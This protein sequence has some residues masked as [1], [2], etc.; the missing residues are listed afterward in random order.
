MA[1]ISANLGFLWT[2]RPL[3]ERIRAAAA[4]GFAAVE[5][6]FPYLH[7]PE[8]IAKVLEDTGL[9][10]V[11][12]NVGLGAGGADDFGLA[13]RPDRRD[14]AREL[15]EQSIAYGTALAVDYVS[16]TSG[17]DITDPKA[18]HVF[19]DNL[20]Y[21][22]DHASPHGINVVIEPLSE[23]AAPG[24]YLSTVEQAIETIDAIDRP[25][26]KLML[27]CFH[28]GVSQGDVIG[29]LRRHARHLGHVQIASVPDRS[30]PD[31]GDLDLAEVFA[32]LDE[33]GYTGWVGAEYHPRATVEAGLDWMRPRTP[34][35]TEEMNR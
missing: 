13:A 18:E 3:P 14:E 22:C 7:T 16:V 15:I 35:R 1:K 6:H 31:H 10:M 8:S 20:T 2:D 24:A 11:G 32:V 9:H 17:K 19:R 30:E 26:M 25:N 34:E 27:D 33:V 21:A 5:C 4:A 28:T 12:L 23:G 29:R